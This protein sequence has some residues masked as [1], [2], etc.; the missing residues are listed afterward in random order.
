MSEHVLGF[1]YRNAAGVVSQRRLTS[2]AE[3]GHYLEG[4][5]EAA[6]KFCTFRKDRVVEY[7][8]GAHAALIEP[9]SSPPPRIQTAS[10][11]DDRPQI[12]FTGFGAAQRA[13]LE[14]HAEEAGLKVVK[15]VTQT[16]VFLCAGPNAGPTKVQKARLQKV[17]I[18]REGELDALLR[19][20]E[21]PDYALEDS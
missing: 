11:K 17:Y 3:V 8:D 4:F 16:L 7:L 1:V 5:D 2:W 15:T 18:I 20:G 12:L 9:H 6:G 13:L 10:P 14:N 19:T 21:L